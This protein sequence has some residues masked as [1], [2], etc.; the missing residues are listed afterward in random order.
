MNYDVFSGDLEDL[1]YENNTPLVINTINAYSYIV[2]K[3]DKK[4]MNSLKSSDILV[5]DGFPIVVAAK[6]LCGEKIIKIAGADIFKY[7]CCKLNAGFGRCFFLGASE[8]TLK[9]IR[10]RLSE[11]YPNIESGFHSPPFKK[12]FSEED[13][14]KMLSAINAFKPNVLFVGMTAPKQEK[15]T[16]LHK[17]DIESGIIAS[18]GAVFDFYAGTTNR[19]SAFWIRLN[20]EWFIRLLKEP[21]RLWKRYLIYSPLFFVNMIWYKLAGK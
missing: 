6:F 7:F 16:T 1:E 20:L 12:E 15:W 19:P 4:F 13:N 10:Q 5:P 3:K 11:E 2:A 14:L 18:I 21:R 17:D 9:K 8:S